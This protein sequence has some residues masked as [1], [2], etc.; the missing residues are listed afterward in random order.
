M[1]SYIPS[2]CF[3]FL[4]KNAMMYIHMFTYI[5]TYYCYYDYSH[6]D[7]PLLLP[8]FN[9]PSNPALFFGTALPTYFLF[10]FS[11]LFLFL[12]L[13]SFLI[14]KF[15]SLLFC[16]SDIVSSTTLL[17]SLHSVA[18]FLFCA[19]FLFIALRRSFSSSLTLTPSACSIAFCHF[20]FS[21]SLI[22]SNSSFASILFF[23]ASNNFRCDLI[24]FLAGP[25]VL[26]AFLSLCRSD[27]APAPSSNMIF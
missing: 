14:L 18:D 7:P 1:S 26:P 6:L 15:S 4:E 10:I 27:V 19:S 13:L 21:F 25:L 24:S 3:S 23:F 11:C 12:P 9:L 2:W 22:C 5:Y 8:V 16:L 17:R 20:P